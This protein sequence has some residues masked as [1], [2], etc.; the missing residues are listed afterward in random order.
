MSESQRVFY[1]R[2]K[3]VLDIVLDG[4]DTGPGSQDQPIHVDNLTPKHATIHVNS[5]RQ[6][7]SWEMTFDAHDAPFDP[8]LIRSA[9][10]KLYLYDESQGEPATDV[11][12]IVGILDEDTMELSDNGRW[13]TMSGQDYTQHLIAKQWPP[14]K[15]GRARRVPTGKRIDALVQDILSE[16]DPSGT[17]KVKL[18]N[19][20]EADLPVVGASSPAGHGRGVP[21]EQNTSYWDVIYKTVLRYGLICF[22]RG[23]DVV[24]SKPKNLHDY[25]NDE[26][27]RMAWGVN[28]SHLTLSRKLGKERVPR[29][30]VIAYDE[31]GEWINRVEYPP[32]GSKL[33]GKFK[34][35]PSARVST[36]EKIKA[37]TARST[38][39]SA[40]ASKTKTLKRED[41]YMIVPIY[42]VSDEKTLLRAAESMRTLIGRGERTIIA[43]TRD[44]VDID[45]LPLLNLQAGDAVEIWWQDFNAETME[46]QAC[47]REQ[48][49]EYLVGRGF[50]PDV[51]E[52]LALQ[53]SR[54]FG[55]QNRPLRLRSASYEWDVSTGVDIEME[56]VD[57][58]VVDG[59]RDTSE[60]TAK[61]VDRVLNDVSKDGK[62]V[63]SS[64]DAL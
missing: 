30:V 31:D 61:T 48:K 7:D 35:T 18:E 41:E 52:A 27:K 58:V 4:Y 13:V 24:I 36:T 2:C 40:K 34:V 50:A 44:L 64:G 55:K 17:L 45:G 9:Q 15:G 60:T 20:A 57:F 14:L 10:V 33:D 6:A 12:L 51:A 42:G 22:V 32:S 49:V 8:Q 59:M 54:M 19:I 26:I 38:G 25:A 21:I 29:I 28:V 5:Y 37:A 23:V 3:A 11:P 63:T 47:S 46:N 16:A 56:L 43:K 39:K 1:P 62:F 53:Y